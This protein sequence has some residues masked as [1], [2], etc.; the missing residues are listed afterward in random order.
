MT[1]IL[2]IATTALAIGLVAVPAMAQEKAAT[3]GDDPVVARVNGDEIRRSEIVREFQSVGSQAAQLPASVLYPQLLEKAIVTKLVSK[4]GYAQKLDNDK[5]VKD[6]LKMS[7]AQIVA[8]IYVHRT[9][10]PK[11]TD[12]KIKSR[13]DQL[14]SKYK[15]EDEVRARHILVPT[16]A[17]A[18]DI[19]KQ[20]KGGADF[21]KL[22]A[23]K[24]KDS[25]SMK[26]GG[27]LGYF[28][29]ESM[30]KPFAD[31]AFALKN[32]EITEKPVKT[33]F[34]YHVIKVEDRRKSAPPPLAEVKDQIMNQVGQEMVQSMIKDMI[35]KAKIERFAPDGTP[36]KS[37]AAKEDK[38]EDKK[39]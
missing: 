34:G 24:S 11:I 30:V 28:V 38:K 1:K 37:P 4:Q 3:A 36:M 20:L 26:Q 13:Y 15:P 27:D 25:G 19:I 23:E 9:I 17:E 22:A 33:D 7:E 31:A 18:S 5:E 10:Q 29:K 21:Q 32:G 16:E 12:D 2:R 35:A 8:D 39:G 14:A 6:R